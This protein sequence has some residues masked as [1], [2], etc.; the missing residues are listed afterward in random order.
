LAYQ[1]AAIVRQDPD[2]HKDVGKLIGALQRSRFP[3]RSHRLLLALAACIAFAC[4]VSWYFIF[5]ASGP[6]LKTDTET[7]APPIDPT[8]FP[9]VEEIGRYVS[10]H[11]LDVASKLPLIDPRTVTF[12]YRNATSTDLRLWMLSCARYFRLNA[13]KNN[14]IPANPWTDLPFPPQR[15]MVRD[16]FERGTGLF[17]FFVY[18]TTR[19]YPAGRHYLF[20]GRR[21]IFTRSDPTL[22]I[23]PGQNGSEDE[24]NAV[25]NVKE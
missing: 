25:F 12:T 6:A 15:E 4:L 8:E 18:R 7:L 24:L 10:E 5:R 19:P 14:L 11:D 20:V 13:D 16:N 17:L 21:C 22:V 3:I 1:N 9:S 2:F 23:T